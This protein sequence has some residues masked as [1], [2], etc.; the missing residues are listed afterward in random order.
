[1]VYATAYL[2]LK[3]QV[4]YVL[5]TSLGHL[6]RIRLHASPIPASVTAGPAAAG[7]QQQDYHDFTVHPHLF[8]SSLQNKIKSGL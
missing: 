4:S 5:Q 3:L 8:T 7:Q 1:M 6:Q 2:C